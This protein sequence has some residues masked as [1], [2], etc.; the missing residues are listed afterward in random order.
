VLV[1]RPRRRHGGRGPGRHAA[2]RP[3]LVP[4]LRPHGVRD[5]RR[6]A[7][8]RAR[9]ARGSALLLRVG[10]GRH[11]GADLRVHGRRAGAQVL[12]LR[13]A[14]G[15][16]ARVLGVRPP[17]RA[18]REPAGHGGGLPQGLH[19]RGRRGRHGA[20]YVAR[21]RNGPRARARR[22]RRGEEGRRAAAS[23]RR[24]GSATGGRSTRS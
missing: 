21:P 14:P 22:P 20:R 15:V 12:L 23:R 6:A 9:A 1:H 18:H 13:P 24:S 7:P 19:R 8:H 17:V 3:E 16:V 5:R 2:V 4:V 11:P 10:G